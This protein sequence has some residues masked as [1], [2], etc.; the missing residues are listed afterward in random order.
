VIGLALLALI[1]VVCVRAALLK[2]RQVAA[3][4]VTDLTVDASAAASRLA[5]ALRFP[6]VSHEDGAN[7]ESQAFLDLHRY[8]EQSFPRVHSTLTREVVA[9]YSLLYTLPGKDPK[10]APIL[11]MSHQDVVPVEPGTEKGW[12]HPAFSGDVA[13]GFVWGRGALDDKVAFWRSWRPSRR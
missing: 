13:D 12:T 4:P 2:S 1:T 8:L 6:T 3:Q 11:L 10:L 9:G 7:V 5:G